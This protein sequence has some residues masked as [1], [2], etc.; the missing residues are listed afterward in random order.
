[1]CFYEKSL[2]IR[3]VLDSN[4]YVFNDAASGS[5]LGRYSDDYF[6]RMRLQTFLLLN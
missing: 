2:R 3:T 4:R 1:M 6:S 5:C